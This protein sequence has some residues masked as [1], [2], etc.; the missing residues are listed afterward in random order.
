VPA[1]FAEDACFPAFDRGRAGD[2]R[3]VRRVAV[4]LAVLAG[5]AFGASPAGEAGRRAA[6]GRVYA[7]REGALAP[8]QARTIDQHDRST[9][10]GGPTVAS[11]GETVKIYFS[12]RYPQDPAFARSW[13][14]FMTSLVHGPE[15]ATVTI[16]LAP[17]TEVQQYCGA[18]AFPCYSSDARA[19][20][21]PGTDPEPG[22]SAKGVLAHEYGHHVAA[23]RLN[24]PFGSG[25]YG[26]KRWSSYE[27]VCA[28]ARAQQL[29]PGAEDSQDYMLNPREAFAESYR[30]LNEQ[31]LG[32][33]Q[34]QWN[35]VSTALYPD[36]TALALLQQDVTQPWAGNT[37]TTLRAT[38]TAKRKA[39][40]FSFATR[41]DGPLS[42]TP[43]K[44]G[45]AKVSVRVQT[46]TG[47]GAIRTLTTATA[48]PL[49]TTICGTR[50]ATAR[51]SL[52]SRVSRTART[53]VTL[54][55]SKP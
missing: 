9:Q 16:V 6:G 26:T 13:A 49:A 39:Q 34:E 2:H 45:S 54:A 44:S 33:P 35:V 18:E 43:R 23:S 10:W 53:T 7:F 19:I 3:A 27:N 24:T 42:V 22:T 25:D 4:A 36:A 51:V 41:L 28:R 55:I 37:T 17:F 14:D 47:A 32:L 5:V 8:A 21:A 29:F 11:N 1:Y 20:I 38:L 30:V 48:R 40:A 50:T 52:A 46:K 12:D 31:R 15:L